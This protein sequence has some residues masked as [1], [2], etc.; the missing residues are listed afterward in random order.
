[1]A[2]SQQT[3]QLEFEESGLS[4]TCKSCEQNFPST[5][6]YRC[7]TC[8]QQDHVQTGGD[9]GQSVYCEDCVVMHLRKGHEIMDSKGYKPAFCTLHK[10]LSLMFCKTCDVVFCFNCLNP[11][12]KHDYGLVSEKAVAVRKEIFTYLDQFDQ[13][14]KPLLKE[15]LFILPLPSGG[16]KSIRTSEQ[17]N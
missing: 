12:C 6:V 13:L 1:M 15:R 2:C 17:I 10:K 3:S 16:M 9:I 11:H 7:Q 8:Q 5:E 4:E 14:S